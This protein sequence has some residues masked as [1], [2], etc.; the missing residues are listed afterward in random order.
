M[1][2]EKLLQVKVPWLGTKKIK[3]IIDEFRASERSK[4][5]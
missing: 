3:P 4:H 5:C 2:Y 1:Q